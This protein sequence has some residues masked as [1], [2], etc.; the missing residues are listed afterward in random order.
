MFN[1]KKYLVL[2]QTFIA[3]SSVSAAET[4]SLPENLQPAWWKEAVIYQIYPRS[5][6]DTNGDGV[7]DLRGIIQQLDYIK[8]LGVNAIWLNPIYQ[9]P[10]DDNGYDISDYRQIGKEYGSMAD[11]DEMLAGMHQRGIKLFMDIVINH[12]S[13]EHEWFKQSRSSR[14]N[15]Y[16]DYYHWWPAEKGKPPHRYSFFDENNDAW[17]YDKQT[18]SYYLHYFSVKQPDLNWGNPKLRHELYDMMK[19]WAKKGVD[20]FRLDA[21]QFVYK[22]P[23]FPE[24]PRDY[25]KTTDGVI[26]YHGMGPRV[27]DYLRELNDEVLTPF[28]IAAVAE[29]AGSTFEDAHSLVDAERKE[30]DIA[31]HF[32]GMNIGNSLD[33]YKLSDFKNVYDR[34]DKSFAEKGWLSI[35]LAN[36][37]VAR[38]VSKF[39][40]D[41]PAYR[42]ASSKL[43]NT[44]LLTMRGT[45]FCYYG[46]ELGMTNIDM[47]DISDYKDIAAINGYKA[48]TVHGKDMQRF[49]LELNLL[50]RDN[51]RTPMQ[52]DNS[53]HA[54]FTDG[55]PWLSANPNYPLI[56]AAKQQDEKDS[57]LNY[58]RQLTQL[59]SE[60][61]VLVYGAYD[62]WL[63]QDEQLYV[64]SRELDD[65]LWLIALNFSD[66]SL[67]TPLQGHAVEKLVL[68]NLPDNP[69]AGS[70]LKLSPYQAV[71]LKLKQ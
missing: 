22:D 46:D 20:G 6:K 65:Q 38:M 56:N 47:P 3:V 37:D 31:Y 34:W 49:M 19:F 40:N 23:T 30:L 11:F 15:P 63:P 39:G 45:I 41:D 18:D 52:W 55:K 59:R 25:D 17:K 32:E 21:F 27:H 13:D 29:G 64:Y 68:N 62:D 10:N 1:F 12:S 9:S 33:G 4:P 71:I 67:V 35:F 36:H 14:D 7:G 8:S 28:N 48:A 26:K 57:V 44:F 66:K 54:G 50:S 43:L 61:P 42:V 69:V 51:A 53:K 2:M 24:F 16:R 70:E 58:F 60:N 5:F